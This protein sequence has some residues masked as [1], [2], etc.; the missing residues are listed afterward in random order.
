L[1]LWLSGIDK[2]EEIYPDPKL[3]ESMAMRYRHDFGLLGKDEQNAIRTT[4][5]QLA[6][7][8]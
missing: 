4:M 1:I 6:V 5:K 7:T 2:T 8:L 3:I